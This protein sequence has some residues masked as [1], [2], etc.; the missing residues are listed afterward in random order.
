M[1]GFSVFD[2]KGNRLFKTYDNEYAGKDTTIE[3]LPSER[4]VGVKSH[5]YR[6]KEA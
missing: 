1:Y 3:L 5:A 6:G 2:R 4:W